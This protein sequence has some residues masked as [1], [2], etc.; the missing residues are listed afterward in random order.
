[1]KKYLQYLIAISLVLVMAVA[2]FAACENDQA[3][4]TAATERTSTVTIEVDGKQITVEDSEGKSIQE[5]LTMAGITLG[6]EDM[7]SVDP[8]KTSGDNMYIQV[9]RM[10]TVTIEVSV[11]DA[12][13]V[14]Y[15]VSCLGGTVA[16]A[17]EEAGVELL[18]NYAVDY[19]LDQP[20]E[21]GMT[22][23]VSEKEDI[24]EDT[25]PESTDGATVP[26]TN[27]NPTTPKPTT[28]KPT[29][30][31]PTTPK[32]TTPQPTTP[33]PTEPKPTTPPTSAPTEPS[34]TIV[35]VE[36]YYDCDGSGHGVKVIT[37]SDGTQEEVY[38]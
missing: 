28:P 3:E 21:N 5:L 33:K 31:K 17:L 26:V 6:S 38:F 13:T 29:T 12:E 32:P 36:Y 1:M 34:R 9:I 11:G 7:V 25:T 8:T 14:R 4:P 35:N 22:I 2:F 30:P 18:D 16:D 24:T 37:Y 19:D 10:N 23:V 20:L 27:P 15:T